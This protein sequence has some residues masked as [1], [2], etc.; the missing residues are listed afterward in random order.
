MSAFVSGASVSAAWVEGL[1]VLLA[2]GGEAVN[3]TVAIADPTAEEP[4]VRAVVDAFIDARRAAQRRSAERVSTVANTIFP[5]SWYIEHLG[6][7]AEKHLYELAAEST[8]VTRRHRASRRG[9]YFERFVAWPL[10]NGESFNQLDQVVQR[11]RAAHDRGQRRG[12]SYEMGLT[13]PTD[14]AVA[15]P[16][17][18]GGRDRQIIGFPC[19]SHTS[20]SLQKG[21][22]HLAAMYRSHEYIR[23]GYGNYVGLGRLLR[24]VANQSGWPVGELT[25]MSASVTVG[26]GAGFGQGALAELLTACRSTPDE[27]T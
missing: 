20:F 10:Q 3:F 24:F 26:G 22:L 4:A 1:A 11:L 5:E 7:G 19:L 23:R 8:S 18:V 14:E 25:C 17:F 13:T 6:E 27:A 12:N 16:V 21:V 15:A 9:T 2:A